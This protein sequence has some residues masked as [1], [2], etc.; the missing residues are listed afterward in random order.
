MEV[1]VEVK[2]ADLIHWREPHGFLQLPFKSYALW[3]SV[4]KLFTLLKFIEDV[5]ELLLI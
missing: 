1:G 3:F 2:Q 4:S 5:K